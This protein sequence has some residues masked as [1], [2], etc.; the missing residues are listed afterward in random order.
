MTHL[1]GKR[2]PTPVPITGHD[3]GTGPGA[4]A[5]TAPT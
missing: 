1:L 2:L 5:G 3:L 4:R